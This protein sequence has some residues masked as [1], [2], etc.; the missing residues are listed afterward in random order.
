MMFYEIFM[1]SMLLSML[2]VIYVL[3]YRGFAS[4]RGRKVLR[5]LIFS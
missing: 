1:S 2:G 5:D 4:R 3:C